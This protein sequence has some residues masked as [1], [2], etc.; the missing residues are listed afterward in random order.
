VP[1]WGPALSELVTYRPDYTDPRWLSAYGNV[2]A[3][4]R[5]W[6]L[7]GG[8]STLSATLQVAATKRVPAIDPGRYV[9]CTRGGSVVWEGQID[10]P[11][12]DTGGGGGWSITAHGN[13]T[14]GDQFRAWWTSWNANNPVDQAIGRGLKWVNPGIGG[15]VDLSVTP[16]PGAQSITEHLNTITD[17]G[18]LTWMIDRWW[19]LR[20][21]PLPATVTR[22][23]LAPNPV[24]RSAVYVN[25]MVIRYQASGDSNGNATYAT[26]SAWNSANAKKHGWNE[27]Y[28]DISNA[29]VMSSGTA[30]GIG[31]NILAK[32]QAA[33]YGGPFT[34]TPGMVLTTGGTPV[35]LGCEKAGEVYR[36]ICMDQGYGGE[37]GPIPPVTFIG[38]G[39]EYDEM[40]LTLTITP[41]QSVYGSFSSLMTALA[42]AAKTRLPG[43]SRLESSSVRLGAGDTPAFPVGVSAHRSVGDQCGV[44]ASPGNHPGP[45]LGYVSGMRVRTALTPAAIVISGW[46]RMCSN[47]RH[48]EKCSTAP[49]PRPAILCHSR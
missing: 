41:F 38:G 40:A 26:T 43:P 37:V 29:G 5:A 20:V 19:R 17:K 1:I 30:Q 13:G 24:A 46:D 2:T 31:N 15:A 27:Q 8:A 6:K 34:A 10:E 44:G 39:I 33:S 49:I 7:P 16:D 28:L 36:L 35:D 9:R 42:P 45:S 47:Y 48:A 3:M 25:A 22:I 11:A 14:Y 32:Y 12:Y 18:A 23:L 21:F 4:K